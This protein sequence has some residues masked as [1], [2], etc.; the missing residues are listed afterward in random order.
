[1]IDPKTVEEIQHASVEDRLHVIEL[2]LQSLK[3]DMNTGAT[4]KQLP[5][6]PFT[7]RQFSL[8]EDV[9]VDRDQLYAERNP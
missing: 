3:R 2:I 9:H 1:M 4:I 8:G 5:H 7:A 6:K